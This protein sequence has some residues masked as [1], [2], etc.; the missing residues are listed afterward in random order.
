MPILSRTAAKS[1]LFP[2]LKN[3]RARSFAMTHRSCTQSRARTIAY[4]A[5]QT[6][7]AII[8][9]SIP[10]QQRGFSRNAVG[11][12]RSRNRMCLQSA[13]ACAPSEDQ[14]CGSNALDR[15]LV[16]DGDVEK[17][18]LILF[19][20]AACIFL[21]APLGSAASGWLNDYK[22]AQQETKAGNK[23]LLL[24]F[25]GSDWCGY[26]IQLD[27][28]VFSQPDFKE[29]ASKNLILLELDFPRPGGSRWQ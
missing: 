7:S 13:S 23:L 20:V 29:Y 8:S 6:K 10:A 5:G 3:S 26:C 4:S 1:S 19:A 12:W 17:R 28:E 11:Y 15:G 16:Q 22:K 2:R 14:A 18:H 27:K 25:T 9:L 21:H 24:D